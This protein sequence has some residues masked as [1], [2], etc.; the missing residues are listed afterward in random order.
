MYRILI[1]EDSKVFGAMTKK[2][3]ESD[4]GAQVEWVQTLADTV[5]LLS[6]D[7]GFFVALLDLHLPD[8]P[9][10]EIV[11]A[12]VSKN[13]PSIIFTAECSD[14]ARKYIWSKRNVVDY[15]IKEGPSGVEY[16]ISLIRRIAL[17]RLIKVLVVDDSTVFRTLVCTL[18]RVHQYV[19]FEARGGR[20]AIRI[21]DKY[22][23]IK[24]IIT[25]F[26]MPDMD[27]IQLTK[28]IRQRYNKEQVAIIGISA[29]EKKILSA[30]FIK[31]G[32]N[33]FIHKPFLSE[34]FYCRVTQN[35]ELLERI[36]KIKELSNKDYMT[37]LYNRRYF[38]ELGRKLFKESEKQ[39]YSIVIAM[40]DIDFFKQINDTYGHDAGDE[41]IKKVSLIL[42]QRFRESD[43]VS[44][45]GG[46][47]FCILAMNMDPNHSFTLFEELRKMI[48]MSEICVGDKTIKTTVSI[49]VCAMPLSSL[50]EMIKQADLMLYKAKKSG[51][52]RVFEV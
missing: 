10:G 11:D 50:D 4:L 1:V 17:N 35:I 33:D 7:P 29:Q 20:E 44:R 2:K 45:F 25:D 48:E 15:V 19:V 21:M 28:K 36:E 41:V 13:I 12:V 34:E 3:I 27:G 38:F 40:V 6:E 52:N 9:G 39:D 23:D 42:K 22:P 8:A 14:K 18:L 24:L 49:G 30:H 46:E 32:A 26:D 31:N 51:R 5:R 37:G 47:E 43:I 16:V